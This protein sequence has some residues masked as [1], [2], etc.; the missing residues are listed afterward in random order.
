MPIK[1][2]IVHKLD[3]TSLG[4]HKETVDF[5]WS[6]SVSKGG[7]TEI[8]IH[9]I[10]NPISWN[11][12]MN[13]FVVFV[14]S[15]LSDNSNFVRMGCLS[16]VAFVIQFNW[17]EQRPCI[18]VLVFREDIKGNYHWTEHWFEFVWCLLEEFF[19]LLIYLNSYS[20]SR[21]HLERVE[22]RW[23]GKD[24]IHRPPLTSP[25]AR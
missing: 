13:R 6:A 11:A 9:Q 7:D 8:R 24:N 2:V 12:Q 15:Q 10:L 21:L 23:N 5:H 19:S 16:L 3:Q 4:D 17:G 20:F 22:Q 18:F 1:S 14:Q 25:A